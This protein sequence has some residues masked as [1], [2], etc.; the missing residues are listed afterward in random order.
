MLSED[1]NIV[2]GLKYVTAFKVSLIVSCCPMMLVI[3][4]WFLGTP[5]SWL[6]VIGV[7][8]TFG[9]MVLSCMNSM[10]KS[11]KIVET[12]WQEILGYLLCFFSAVFELLPIF[13]RQTIKYVPL[14]QVWYVSCHVTPILR[15]FSTHL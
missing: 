2:I 3:I 11:G 5:V 13:N 6:E 4:M 1:V 7:C 8:V 15:L 12:E 10:D 14:W 9:G